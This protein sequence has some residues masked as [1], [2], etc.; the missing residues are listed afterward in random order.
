LLLSVASVAQKIPGFFGTKLLQKATYQDDQPWNFVRSAAFRKS[1][2]R[3]LKAIS[4]V[5]V[6]E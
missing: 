5:Q 4:I 2:F 1:A 3:L 6:G